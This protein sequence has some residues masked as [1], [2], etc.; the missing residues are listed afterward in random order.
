M[1]DEFNE[2]VIS[3]IKRDHMKCNMFFSSSTKANIL[4]HFSLEIASL[5]TGRKI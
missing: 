4:Y 2:G 1:Q 3:V 5:K